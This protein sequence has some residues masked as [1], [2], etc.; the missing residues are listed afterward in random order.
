VPRVARPDEA[1]CRRRRSLRRLPGLLQRRQLDESHLIEGAE[2]QGAAPM[3]NW[4]GDE[5]ATTFSY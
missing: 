1:L 4:I 3:W 5:G 2:I